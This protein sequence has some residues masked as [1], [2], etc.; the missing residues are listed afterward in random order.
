MNVRFA[1]PTRLLKLRK[2]A[3]L[4]QSQLASSIYGAAK[5][6]QRVGKIERGEVELEFSEG[7]AWIYAC[8]D[9]S[10]KRELKKAVNVLLKTKI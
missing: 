4:D 5:K 2:K 6:R 8:S 7:L 3:K 9:D 1:T 10:T